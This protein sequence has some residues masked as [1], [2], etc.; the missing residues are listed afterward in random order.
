MSNLDSY[1]TIAHS[2]RRSVTLLSIALAAS[3][4]AATEL[5]GA[6]PSVA[7]TMCVVAAAIVETV[8]AL[9]YKEPQTSKRRIYHA[10]SGF[11]RRALW[12]G[13][14]A[15][16]ALLII[17]E[18]RVPR[19]AAAALERK[20]LHASSEPTL[21]ESSRTAVQVLERAKAAGV[22]LTPATLKKAG[23]SFLTATK[24][25][26]A[27]MEAALALANYRS[28][29]NSGPVPLTQLRPDDNWVDWNMAIPAPPPGQPGGAEILRG[30]QVPVAS[31]AVFESLGQKLNV[32]RTVGPAFMNFLFHS[33]ASASIDG[34]RMKHIIF[35]SG[36][37]YYHGGPIEMDDVYFVNCTFN[38]PL[39]SAN[40][41]KFVT[42]VLYGN[43]VF[44]RCYQELSS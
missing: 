17:S 7:L 22:E 19:V 20:L 21:L 16:I 1:L 15:A 3:A 37:I 13:A 42:A 12:Q 41:R 24:V 36:V 6:S 34:A 23:D 28:S 29:L 30:S 9:T 11:T 44:L 25:Q 4:G 35:T 33:G 38:I 8:G 39:D 31:A 40:G 14:R 43:P 5:L 18:I 10:Q 27:A 32:G 2:R 26:P